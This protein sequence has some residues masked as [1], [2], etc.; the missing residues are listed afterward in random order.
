MTTEADS[1]ATPPKRFI[2]TDKDMV[3]FLESPAKTELLK[4][5]AAMGKSCANPDCARFQYDPASPLNGL[6]PATASL[7]GSLELMATWL[8]EIPPQKSQHIRFGNPAFREWHERLVQRSSS[9]SW[10]VIQ[11]LKKYPGHQE[12]DEDAISLASEMGKEAAG[13]VLD[14]QSLDEEDRIVVIELSAY[15]QAA[16]GHPIRLDY[17]TGHECSFQ[18]FLFAICKLGGFGSTLTEPPSAERLKAVTLSLWTAYLQVTRRLQTEYMLEPAGSHG[19]WGLDDYHCL[20]FYFGACQLQVDGDEL[21]PK[22]THDDGI[23][24]KTGDRFLYFGCIRYIKSLKKGVPFFESSPMLNDIS[25]LNSWEKVASGLLRLFEGEVLK[26]RQVVQHFVFGEI[27][28]A[29]WKPS[30]A[31]K[32]P[33]EETFRTDPGIPTTARAPWATTSSSAGNI[34]STKAP[35][36]K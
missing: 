35:W 8:D 24:S 36:A 4:V 27:F 28:K 12:Y 5:T 14:E 6:S 25:H 26:K 18:V 20:P 32:M 30:D 21:T 9:I 22:S 11:M 29:N 17:G 16:F 19:V 2:F 23:L 7:H 10:A 31:P 3:H 34:P 33:P 1:K 13:N 15:L